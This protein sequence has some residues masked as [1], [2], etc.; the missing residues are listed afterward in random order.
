MPDNN[1]D[2]VI[3]S[4]KLLRSRSA[5][6]INSIGQFSDGKNDNVITLTT[7]H[8]FLTGESVRVYSNTG[9]LPD[10][11]T[12]NTIFYA[13]TS[14]TGIST[15]T[16]IKLAKTRNDAISGSDTINSKGGELTVI[17]RELW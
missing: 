4:E 6:G 11:L 2:P 10:G 1:T 16:N 13:I 15:S 12:P 8:K 7:D 9:Q 17:S 5:A 3:S 14:G